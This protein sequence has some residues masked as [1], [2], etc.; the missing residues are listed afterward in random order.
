MKEWLKT[1]AGIIFN[2]EMS[3]TGGEVLGITPEHPYYVKRNVT[4]KGASD[5][6]DYIDVAFAATGR[7]AAVMHFED[8]KKVLEKPSTTEVS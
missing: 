4:V 1:I 5:R 8:F 7:I 6:P 3:W 2:V